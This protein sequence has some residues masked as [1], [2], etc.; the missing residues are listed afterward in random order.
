MLD[1]KISTEALSKLGLISKQHFKFFEDADIIF[2]PFR[3]LVNRIFSVFNGFVNWIFASSL[4][5]K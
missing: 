1:N 4:A 5:F 2:S 3:D